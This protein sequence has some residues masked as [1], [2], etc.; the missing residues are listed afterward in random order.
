MRQPKGTIMPSFSSISL[1]VHCAILTG[2][3]G[4]AT[5][6]TMTL[7]GGD[8]ARFLPPMTPMIVA[9]SLGAGLAGAILA[10]GF[11][12]RG[13]CGVVTSALLWPF[14]TALGAAIAA[15]PF[16]LVDMVGQSFTRRNMLHAALESAPRGL[17]AVA[18]GILFSPVVAA[19]WAISLLGLQFA[20]RAERSA[21]I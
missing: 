14:T 18:D 16:G 19:I 8:L 21:T 20:M 9:A 15:M 5:A 13:W 17:V 10:D 3:A 11:G 7:W 6:Q 12:R 4:G 2:I 1:R